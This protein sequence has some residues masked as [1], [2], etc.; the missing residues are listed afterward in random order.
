M[1]TSRATYA[2]QWR[3][4]RRQSRRFDTLASD[5]VLTKYP[6]I[7]EEITR[8]YGTLN[9]KYG[10]K[11]NLTKTNEY[12]QWKA[13]QGASDDPEQGTSSTT[14]TTTEQEMSDGPE[15]GTSSTTPTTTEQEM[16][17]EAEQGTSSTTPTTTEQEMSDEPE[18]GT[19]S[20][21]PTTTE[22][23]M[24]DDLIPQYDLTLDH[25]DNIINNIINELQQDEGIRALMDEPFDFELQDDQYNW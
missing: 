8:F 25:M 2:R 13:E 6:A 17:D 3:L 10:T 18:Q 24:S 20:T 14:P 19:S 11:H 23:G 21:T 4:G 12:R 7:H 22:Q 15:Q 1:A 9:S 16:S 5:Y